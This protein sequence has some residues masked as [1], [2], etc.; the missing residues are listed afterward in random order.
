MGGTTIFGASKIA[1]TAGA[2]SSDANTPTYS[3]FLITDP[4]SLTVTAT[5]SSGSETAKINNVSL[6]GYWV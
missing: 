2:A 6:S 3:K 5:S 4:S 1:V